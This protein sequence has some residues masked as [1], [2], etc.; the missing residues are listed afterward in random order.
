[1][2]GAVGGE[3][4]WG[5]IRGASLQFYYPSSLTFIIFLSPFGSSSAVGEATRMTLK[6]N[7]ESFLVALMGC[8]GR[9]EFP[10]EK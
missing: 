2:V 8:L 7:D 1:M 6:A 3:R 9:M 4:E 10:F 5:A